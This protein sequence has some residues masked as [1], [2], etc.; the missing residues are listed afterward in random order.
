MTEHPAPSIADLSM[1]AKPVQQR[2]ADRMQHLLDAAATL[3]DEEGLDAVTTTAV[4][5]RSRSSVG[6]LYRYFPNVDS[7]LKALAQRNMQRYLDF[8][9]TGSDRTPDVPW[10]SWNNTL[11]SYIYMYLNEPGFRH[12]GFGDIINERFLDAELSNN[13]LVARAFAQQLSETH[14]VPITDTMLFHLDVAIAMGTALVHR[15]FLYDPRGDQ[16]FIEQAR[17]IVGN[18][19]R[20]KLPSVNG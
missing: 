5:Y 10:S 16:R 7:L 20:T 19:L 14:S 8:V 17:E 3:I 15:A 2:S 9:E 12:L 13:S 1:R 18:H 6:V 4:A 11:D